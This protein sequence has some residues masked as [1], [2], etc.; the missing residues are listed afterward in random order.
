MVPVK[1]LFLVYFPF[2]MCPISEHLV[3]MGLQQ[4]D[5]LTQGILK[6]LFYIP[7]VKVQAEHANINQTT[8]QQDCPDT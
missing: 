8:C 6:C 1:Q 3:E 2:S 7:G 4:R 5:V